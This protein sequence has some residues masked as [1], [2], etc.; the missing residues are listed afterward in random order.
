MLIRIRLAILMPI[1]LR[2]WIPDWHQIMR[3]KCG[4]FPKFY[5][6]WKIGTK[7]CY[8]YSQQWQLQNNSFH[9][10]GK[11]VMILSILDSILKFSW[12]SKKNSFAWNWYRLAGS[13]SACPRYQSWSG[14]FKIMRIWPY[15]DPVILDRIC[16]K[17][18]SLGASSFF[19]A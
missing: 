4:S 14:S 15:P 8:F 5:T 16:K 3:S 10:S 6:F 9:M 7:L 13:G 2:V 12:K 1:Q 11:C 17:R 18:K 19:V